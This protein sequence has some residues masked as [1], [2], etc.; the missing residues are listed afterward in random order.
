[1]DYIRALMCVNEK[2]EGEYFDKYGLSYDCPPRD[3]L[4]NRVRLIYSTTMSCARALLENRF[5]ICL[6]V[7]EIKFGWFESILFT[8]ETIRCYRNPKS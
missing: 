7:G 4:Y 5:D 8:K 2:S 1:M 6:R 3:K